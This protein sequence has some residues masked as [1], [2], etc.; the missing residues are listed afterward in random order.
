V[1]IKINSALKIQSS[2]GIPLL[3]EKCLDWCHSCTSGFQQEEVC[4]SLLTRK[5]PTV[6][7]L[8]EASSDV[9]FVLFCSE[10]QQVPQILP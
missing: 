3:P 1:C 10:S 9:P 6:R 7:H 8:I 2:W 5:E 4:F